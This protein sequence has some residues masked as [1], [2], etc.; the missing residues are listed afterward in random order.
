MLVTGGV[1]GEGKLGACIGG[2][3]LNPSPEIY[4]LARRPTVRVNRTSK[5]DETHLTRVSNIT[6]CNYRQSAELRPN[7]TTL[8]EAHIGFQ[9]RTNKPMLARLALD[10]LQREVRDGNGGPPNL[11]INAHRSVYG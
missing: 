6:V 10:R 1:I 7:G 3:P 5:D 11:P 2:P 9:E 4:V 8:D